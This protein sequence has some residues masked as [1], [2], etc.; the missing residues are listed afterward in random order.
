MSSFGIVALNDAHEV[1]KES[2]FVFLC[3]KPQVIE[4]V[5][6]DINGDLKGKAVVSI[7]LG[8][9]FDKYTIRCIYKTSNSYAKYSNGSK[10]RYVSIR[11]DSFFD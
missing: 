8:Y 10:R 3:V 5:V 7:V 9:D 1:V 4:S 2:D 6:A 11:T